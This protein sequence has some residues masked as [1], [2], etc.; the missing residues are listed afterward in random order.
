MF[1]GLLKDKLE[2]FKDNPKYIKIA[3]IIGI[4]IILIIYLFDVFSSKPT[5]KIDNSTNL[6]TEE[7]KEELEK[8]LTESLKNI[9]GVGKVKVMIT[10]E[11]NREVVYENQ[12]EYEKSLGENDEKYSEKKST[13][14]IDS[15]E[16]DNGLIKRINEPEIRGV[17]VVCDGGGNAGVKAKVT[18]AVEKLFKI[19]SAR[20]CVTN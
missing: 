13:V 7:Y 6:Q 5:K 20:V 8:Q 10:L 11:S 14:I 1:D 2:Q 18:E 15:G 4:S 12:K 3:F 19:S 16:A 9:G 17:L